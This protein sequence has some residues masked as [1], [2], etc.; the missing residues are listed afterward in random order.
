MKRLTGL[1]LAV[2]VGMG[3]AGSRL[4][5]HEETFKGT[6]IA[7]QTAKVQVSVIDDKSKKESS[8]EFAVTSK[9]K[10]LRGDKVV[11]FAD[12]K[13]TKGERIAVTVDHDASMSDAVVIRLAVGRLK[14]PL[15]L[16]ALSS[17][18]H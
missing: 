17:G 9:T 10:V 2:V 4:L 15:N 6:V 18:R 3:V 7:T 14:T 16:R 13:I 12:A 5:A 8:M 11:P 1:V